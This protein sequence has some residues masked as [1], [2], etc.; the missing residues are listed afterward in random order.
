MVP[1]F[2]GIQLRNKKGRGEWTNPIDITWCSSG[3]ACKS[4][5][6]CRNTLCTPVIKQIKPQN[7]S[8]KYAYKVL[9]SLSLNFEA[10]LGVSTREQGRLAESKCLIQQ[11]LSLTSFCKSYTSTERNVKVFTIF[12][13]S[14]QNENFVGLS[15]PGFISKYN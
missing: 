1:L 15:V 6:H 11:K 14:L 10:A 5:M 13:R 9:T 3:T 7:C 12:M 8:F 4:S 2:C